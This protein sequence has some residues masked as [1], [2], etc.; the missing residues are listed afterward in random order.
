MLH[1]LRSLVFGRVLDRELDAEVRFHIEMETQKYIREGM[2]PHEARTRAF[3]NFGPIE[4]HKEEAR[5]TRGV[6]R[7][8]ELVRDVSYGT[9]TLIKHPGFALLAILTLGLGIGANTAIFSVMNAA[10][11][12]RYPLNEPERLLRVYGEDRQ[13]GTTQLGFSLPRFECFREHQTSFSSFA[14][15]NYNGFALDGRNGAEQVPGASVTSDFFET[16]GASPLLGRFMRRDEELGG[17]VVVLGEEMWRGRFGASPGVLGQSLTL[18]GNIYTVIGVAPRLPAFW[19]ADVWLPDPFVVPGLTRELMQRGVTFLAAVGRLEPGV[20]QAEATRELEVLTSRYRASFSA[21]ADSAW[22]ATTVGLRDDIVGAARSSLLTLLAAVALLLVVACANVANLLLVRFTGR[23]QEIGLRTALGASR[24]RIVRQFLVESTLL[25]GLAAA[26]GA[27]LAYL[28]LPALI[29]LADNNLAFSEDIRISVPVLIATAG[30]ALVAGLA[31]GAYP[32]LQGSRADIVSALRDGG[33]TVAGAVASHRARRTIVVAQ[34]AL[35]L[36]LLIGA[37]LLVTSFMRLRSQPVG[38]AANDLFIGGLNLPA[39]RYPDPASQ[40]RLYMDLA[41]AANET[42][43]VVKAVMA[44][45]VPLL[46]PFTRAPYASAEGAMPPL[47]ERPLGLTES[48][49]PGYFETLQIPLL[50]GR[51]FTER[52]TADAPLVVIV[53]A[54]TARRLFPDDDNVLGRRVIM[55]SQGGGQI[56]QIVGVAGDVRSQT[57]ASHPDVEFYR[58]VFQR[59]RTFMQL[60][61]RTSVDAASFEPTARQIVTRIDSALPLTGVTTLQ[62]VLDQSLAQQRLLFTLLGV[63]AALAVVLSAVGIYG[64]VASFVGQRT[65]EIGVRVALG[66]RADEIVALVMRQSLPPVAIGLVV[67]LIAT[68]ALSQFVQTLLFGVS[69]VD[70]LMLAGASVAL[71]AVATLACALPA[72]RA[73]RISPIVALRGV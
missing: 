34:V 5:E 42:P 61:A 49:T 3:R 33:R 40:N 28:S 72:R 29:V 66:A 39:A 19:D 10:Y 56:M 71:G 15:A 58:P 11:F 52:D 27:G 69:A 67:G 24:G 57:L 48:V 53:S 46:G 7:F 25:S 45:T 68:V 65:I 38:F 55:G 4:K 32:S 73:A 12:S 6:M 35:S 22:A 13:R 9:R 23:R 44:Q 1:R 47:N 20:T 8:E 51:D 21:N 64:V 63:F 70:P 18:S 36:V 26:V 43:G 30:L 17:R 31:M 14:A 59:P 37:T 16:F 60:V 50:A 62:R 2:T 41:R 54:S